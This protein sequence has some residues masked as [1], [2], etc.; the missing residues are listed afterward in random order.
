M[1]PLLR[2]IWIRSLALLFPKFAFP[3]KAD[4]SYAPCLFFFSLSFNILTYMHELLETKS[5]GFKA[6][7]VGF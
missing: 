2:A 6:V 5:G 7:C 4:C 3:H 1:V